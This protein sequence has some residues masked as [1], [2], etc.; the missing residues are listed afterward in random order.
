MQRSRNLRVRLD[1]L[2]EFLAGIYETLRWHES[3]LFELSASAMAWQKLLER[4]S[5]LAAEFQQIR[6]GIKQAQ[7]ETPHAIQLRLY[8]EI[9]RGDTVHR[10]HFGAPVFASIDPEPTLAVVVQRQ[11][12]AE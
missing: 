3:L 4:N 8:D 7:L 11:R 6:Q 12:G 2:D 10:L 1:G 9:M 5:V